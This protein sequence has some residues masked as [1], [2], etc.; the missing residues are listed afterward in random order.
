MHVVA[1]SAKAATK[2]KKKEAE[3]EGGLRREENPPVLDL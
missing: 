3:K 2:F 1:S